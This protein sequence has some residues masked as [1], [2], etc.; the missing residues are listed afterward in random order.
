MKKIN[1]ILRGMTFLMCL[2]SVTVFAQSN[3]TFNGP[4]A[5]NSNACSDLSGGVTGSSGNLEAVSIDI[6]HTWNGDLE[7]R[8]EAPNG[9]SVLLYDNRGG[10]T[11]NIQ[12]TFSD[13]ASTPISSASG[14]PISGT[15]QPEE[16]LSSLAGAGDG[17]WNLEVCDLVGGDNGTILSYTLQFGNSG[18]PTPQ[19][20]PATPATNDG[21]GMTNL[22]LGS[23]SF[24]LPDLTY[25]D[26][27][28]TPVDFFA[29]TVGNVQPTFATGFFPYDVFIYI[30]VNNDYTFDPGSELFFTGGAP[31]NGTLDASFQMPSTLGTYRMRIASGDDCCGYTGAPCYTGNWAVYVDAT[32]NVIEA[33]CDAATIG[34]VSVQEDCNPSNPVYFVNV[35][36]QTGG[37][38]LS[39][40][41]NG[42]GVNANFPIANTGNN[43]VG[44]FPSGVEVNLTVVHSDSQCDIDLGEFVFYCPPPNDACADAIAID[45][46]TTDGTTIASTFNAPTSFCGTFLNTPGVWY[47]YAG[48]G[49]DI[50]ADVCVRDY[51]TK[52]AVFEG[53]CNNLVC[54]TGNDD[55]CG[56]GSRVEFSTVVGTNYYIYVTGFSGATGN[57]TL[58]IEC[59]CDVYIAEG[60]CVKVFTGYEPSAS[61]QLTAVGQFGEGPYTYEWSDGQ[62]GETITVAPTSQ[63]TYTVTMTDSAGCTSTASTTVLVQDISCQDNG[64]DN[65]AKVNICHNGEP[66]CVSVNAVQSHLNHGDSLSAC[67]DD[68]NCSTAPVCD[69]RLKV[70]NPEATDVSV[71][72]EISWGAATGYVEGYFL[73][74]GTTSGGTDILN[75]VDVGNVLD[76][77]LSGDL[78]YNT[79]YYVTVVPYNN[80]GI[81][82]DCS[83]SSFFTTES[84]PWCNATSIDCNSSASGNTA[85]DGEVGSVPSCG[86]FL[87]SAPGV[88]YTFVGTGFDV[89]AALCNSS[90]DTKIGVFT[91]DCSSISCVTGTDDGGCGFGL[92]SEVDFQTVQG[93]TYYIYVTGFS[94]SAGAYTLDLTCAGPPP[95]NPACDAALNIDCNSTVSGTTTG[96]STNDLDFCGTSLTSAP[97]RFYKFEPSVSGAHSVT[98]CAA[99]GFDTK[100]GVFTSTDCASFTCVGGDDDDFCSFSGLRS[101]VNFNAV[102]GN[103]YYIYVTGFGG[104]N[105]NFEL[106]LTCPGAREEA[107]TNTFETAEWTLYP[108]PATNGEVELDLS[109]YLNQEVSIQM[110]D[111]SGKVMVD[112]NEPNL[113]TPRYRLSTS[114]MSYGM[115]FVRVA[116]ESGVS[117]K[118]LI[119]ANN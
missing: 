65:N 108:N 101:R 16:P 85:T 29:G 110:M 66:L 39:I 69:A 56:L 12:V 109:N 51:D 82:T 6:Q 4:V 50:I 33:P 91:G 81:A 63:T 1:T 21:A 78:D 73:S 28:A 87:S 68:V 41:A 34:T 5:I 111:F 72:V 112:R 74:V 35:D 53:D 8:L 79:T 54:I 9:S 7:I 23:T 43:Q 49:G 15:Y 98:T 44:P 26:L 99:V 46:G 118:K 40:V 58:D 95:V 96:F 70:P 83:D 100:L 17:V 92:T 14:S 10:N 90:Y 80:I 20:C 71:N 107:E 55:S 64:N 97:G 61:T 2:F 119:I 25:H 60:P 47:V 32:I 59:V 84:G 106:T 42:T 18:P 22:E 31:G 86:T 75:N 94:S 67:N 113:Q 11:D 13:S 36:V 102:V 3:Y 77:D 62:M 104:S 24:P 115:Y 117:T 45:C 93:E 38:A 57:F 48:T 116:T 88:W 19:Y 103:T 37:D 105:G 89:N 76:Y 27:T 52:L 114:G 30:D